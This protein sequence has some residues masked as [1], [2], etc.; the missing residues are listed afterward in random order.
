[1]FYT[2]TKQMKMIMSEKDE[3]HLYPNEK[4]LTLSIIYQYILMSY[5]K[6]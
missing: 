6:S 3:T 5:D 2:S 1:M 4:R